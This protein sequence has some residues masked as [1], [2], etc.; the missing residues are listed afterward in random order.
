MSEVDRELEKLLWPA[1][2]RAK[3]KE[4]RGLSAAVQLLL[5]SDR[6]NKQRSGGAAP[7]R[8][9]TPAAGGQ[10][11]REELRAHLRKA[12]Q[13]MVKITGKSRGIAGVRD[14]LE[15]IGDGKAE[16][17]VEREGD[18][19][20]EG[21]AAAR[22]AKDDAQ[23][24][25]RPIITEAGERIDTVGGLKDLVKE[26]QR[27]PSPMPWTSEKAEAVHVM[28]QMP[29]GTDATKLLDAVQAAARG[30]FEGHRY[31][32]ALH[33]H[34][35]SPHVHLLVRVKSNDGLKRLN[36]R[37]A[38]LHRWRLRFAHELRA[39]GIDAAASR[40]RTRGYA[41]RHE[42][43]WEKKMT[44]REAGLRERALRARSL[45]RDLAADDLDARAEAVRRTPATRPRTQ[46]AA[47]DRQI[48]Q[49]RAQWEDVRRALAGSADSADRQ[50]AEATAA[51]MRQEFGR[52]PGGGIEIETPRD[53]GKGQAR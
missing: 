14:H 31:A 36:P 30:E 39:R 13:V 19:R 16:K 22:G 51:F 17:Y 34:Q 6:A 32:L 23:R 15:Y 35:S 9:S 42:H 21:D 29:P 43:L 53:Q 11:L 28:W 5:S 12:P 41:Q 49:A 27:S 25:V 2:K 48:A 38:D 8:P 18:E 47:T 3:S 33:Q 52:R 1:P 44:Q 20:A 10:F 45:G 26:W 46:D 37:K 4:P 7:D 50:L 40:Q 24:L